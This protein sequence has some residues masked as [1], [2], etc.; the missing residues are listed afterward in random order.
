MK[1]WAAGKR[2]G[3]EEEEAGEAKETATPST[4]TTTPSVDNAPDANGIRTVE[5]V[6]SYRCR[7]SFSSTTRTLKAG[8]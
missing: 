7:S 6:P 2:W 3:D 4:T 5:E 8:R 1:K